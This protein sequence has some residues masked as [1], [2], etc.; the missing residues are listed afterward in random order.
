VVKNLR[1]DGSNPGLRQ[2][3]K[4]REGH[5]RDEDRKRGGISIHDQNSSGAD[6]AESQP[7]VPLPVNL[8]LN[9]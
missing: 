5:A 2:H 3:D 8:H 9:L 6:N 1:G 7:R 4:Q